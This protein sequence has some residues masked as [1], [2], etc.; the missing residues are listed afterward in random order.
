MK[1]IAYVKKIVPTEIEVPDELV[2]IITDSINSA[3]K[4]AIY[5]YAIAVNE[6]DEFIRIKY[7][8]EFEEDY[9]YLEGEEKDG[10]TFPLLE[11]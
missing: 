6:L 7:G 11:C 8:I 9:E 3:S 5:T 2:N 1:A 4:K 10:T